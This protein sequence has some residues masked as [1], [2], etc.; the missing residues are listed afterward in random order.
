MTP[1]EE[2]QAL[3]ARVDEL[4]RRVA[5]LEGRRVAWTAPSTPPPPKPEP[6]LAAVEPP[7]P[8]VVEP[9]SL[10][11]TREPEPEPEIASL[12]TRVGLAWVNR[13]AVVTCIFA[14]A[15]FFKYAVDNEWIGPRGRILLGVL[16]GLVS[17]FAADRFHRRGERTYAQGLLALGVALLYASFFAAHGFYQLIPFAAAFPLMAGAALLGGTLAIR[18]NS[19]AIAA[20]SLAGGVLTPMLLSSGEFRA[21]FFFSYVLSLA[22]GARWAAHR[23]GWTLIDRMSLAA[24]AWLGYLSFDGVATTNAHH[25]LAIFAALAYAL[26]SRWAS[27]GVRYFAQLAFSLLIAGA[28]PKSPLALILLIPMAWE[29]LSPFRAQPGRWSGLVT[30]LG[31]WI[32]VGTWHAAHWQDPVWVKLVP[33][34]GFLILFLIGAIRMPKLGQPQAALDIL[35]LAGPLFFTPIYLSLQPALKAWHG[36]AAL[37]VAGLY[38]AAGYAVRIDAR[39]SLLAFGMAL[40]FLTLAVPLQFSAFRITM[41]WAVQGAALAWLAARVNSTKAAYG[42]LVVLAL[43][44]LNLL[45]DPGSGAT[46]IATF[47]VLAFAL[48]LAAYWLRGFRENPRIALGPY[49][50]GHAIALWGIALELIDATK[51]AENPSSAASLA[52]S[53]LGAVYGVA[54]VAAGVATRTR[55]NR[56]LG[57]GL[58]A[59]VIAKLYLSDIWSLGLIHRVVA[60]GALGALLL[61]TSFLYSRFRPKI[62]A[63]LEE[64]RP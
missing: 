39:A 54:L 2:I 22:A 51:T 11:A 8:P 25:A 43:A 24:T 45:G 38:T 34:Y 47:A 27:D 55:I 5:Q 23:Q 28:A 36:A 41:A 35:L 16:A 4:D 53:I 48:W 40:A 37:G 46:R 15:F 18:Y 57:L 63:L 56:L 17:I 20:L 30:L 59:L 3:R 31:A 12:E 44:A 19:E 29:G 21:I 42:A 7:P 62:E 13:L 64:E 60:F 6:Q 32:V 33:E 58:I 50:I 26:H 61:A 9:P 14:A 52:I 10:F 1:E 49:V